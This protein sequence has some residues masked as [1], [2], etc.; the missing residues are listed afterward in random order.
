M[1]NILEPALQKW[2][3]GARLG[4]T[5]VIRT[6]GSAP[7]PVG[8]SQMTTVSGEVIGS[9][10]GGC[11]ESAVYEANMACLEG[12]AP[13]LNV[14][15]FGDTDAWEVGL[16]CGGTLETFTELIDATT[17]P[18]LEELTEAKR[19]GSALALVTVVASEATEIRP[20]SKLLV[21]ADTVAGSLGS[22]GLDA[23]AVTRARAAIGE[24]RH[25]VIELGSDPG[26]SISAFVEV[27][28]AKPRLIIFGAVDFAAALAEAGAFLGYQVTVCDAREVF[29]TK[30]RLPGAHELV[31]QWPHR[32]LAAEVG[33][34]RVDERTA[35]CVLT[36]DAKFDVP[37][38]EVALR[39][40]TGNYVGALG[41][42]R[43]HLERHARLVAT[44]LDEEELARLH[45]PIGLDLGAVTPAET[46]VSIMAEIIA[47]RSGRT[48][49]SL[50]TTRGAIHGTEP[51][52]RCAPM[53]V[54]A[55][56]GLAGK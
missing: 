15:G 49:A 27:F 24:N 19:T 20:G 35:L 36:H 18:W 9:V 47:F 4:I 38:L 22:D 23:R 34:G 44:G 11:V 6:H 37:L 26:K 12:A 39:L 8:F 3:L 16:T 43:T 7:L 14:F 10:S 13:T 51:A 31:S 56:S 46:A 40:P 45:S 33:T 17:L 52:Q 29:L 2:R 28:S 21:R 48:G 50:R 30:E 54:E 32:Y 5:T 55:T 41:S 42:R 53:A 25:E 1:L